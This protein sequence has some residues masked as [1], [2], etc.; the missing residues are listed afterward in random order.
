[1]TQLL[2]YSQLLASKRLMVHE[3]ELQVLL[4]LL[5]RSFRCQETLANSLDLPGN[6]IPFK[7]QHS[8]LYV[9]VCVVVVTKAVGINQ[10]M[11]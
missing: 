4:L 9:P 11:H 5:A 3:V 7:E 2:G 8:Q 6:P 10:A 1:M